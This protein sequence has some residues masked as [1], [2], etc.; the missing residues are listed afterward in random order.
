M[1]NTPEPAYMRAADYRRVARGALKGNWFS[2]CV[3]FVII[4]V[5]SLGI[6]ALILAISPTVRLPEPLTPD[7]IAHIAEHGDMP[8]MEDLTREIYDAI[9]NFDLSDISLEYRDMSRWAWALSISALAAFAIA[10]PVINVGGYATLIPLFKGEKTSYRRGFERFGLIFKAFGMSVMRAL[11]VCAGLLLFIVPGIILAYSYCMAEYIMARNPG[12][13]ALEALRQSR[14]FM[15]G[16]K[17]RFF[18]LSLSFIGWRLLAVL[19]CTLL[20]AYLMVFLS[21]FGA[22]SEEIISAITQF[23]PALMINVYALT[24]QTAFFLDAEREYK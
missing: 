2:A 14:V 20:S 6:Q 16:R 17:T 5:L 1:E 3:Y 22:V 13:G 23:V 8:G 24:A 21:A 7:N 4:T 10:S 15:R 12:A 18:C 19:G 11:A 9:E